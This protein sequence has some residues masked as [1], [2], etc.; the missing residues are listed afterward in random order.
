MEGDEKLRKGSLERGE[1]YE[2][3]FGSKNPRVVK[4]GGEIKE[5]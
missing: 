1:K 3:K 2:Y 5:K 4:R